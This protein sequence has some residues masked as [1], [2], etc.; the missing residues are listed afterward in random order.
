MITTARTGV[1]IFAT[2]TDREVV[3]T[4]VV[5]APR[6]LVFDVHTRPEHLRRWLGPDGWSMPVCEVDLRPGGAY[7]YVWRKPSGTE[8]TITGVVREVT[9][10]ERFVMTEVW[11]PEWPETV[12]TT[13]FTE[14]AGRT[15]ITLTIT[16]ASREARDA[17][18]ETGMK[19]GSEQSY[20]RLDKLLQEL[21]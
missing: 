7:R 16:Y 17:A 18:L 10:P 15:T 13:V 11:G 19:D 5:A 14:S 20:G 6:E 21:V 8:I 1:T 3:I 12:N 2:P 4:R 9:R